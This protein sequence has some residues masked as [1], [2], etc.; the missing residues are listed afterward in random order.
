MD[1]NGKVKS[2]T[3]KDKS[4]FGVQFDQHSLEKFCKDCN[5]NN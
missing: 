3:W 4:L 2:K 5:M 1:I